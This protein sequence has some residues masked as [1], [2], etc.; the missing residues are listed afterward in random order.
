MEE[1]SNKFILSS[2]NLIDLLCYP[3]FSA[4]DYYSRLTELRSLNLKFVILEGNTLLKALRILGKGSEGLVLK[5][6][7][8]HS[9]TMALKIKRIDSCRINMKNEFE[10]YQ[11]INRNH[12]GPK[13][14]SYTKNALLMEFIEGLSA[15]DWF[16]NSKMNIDLIRKIIT[17]IL[18]QCYILDKLHIDH[19]QLNKLDNHVIISHCGSKCTIV[20]FESASC[21]R[22]VN[23]VTSAFH[24]LIFKGIIADKINKLVNY[25]KKRVEF[26]N[27]LSNYKMDK[28]KK[29][30]DSII[31][32]I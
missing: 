18:T 19:G 28:S 13:V 8:I 12:L 21:I 30:F 3:R 14:Y 29:N 1:Y 17:N 26:L 16:L 23:N 11:L 5:V 10:F 4:P 20:D 22:K 6:Q 31:A 32:S 7:N 2:A 15:R 25:D 9:K 24:G 27:L